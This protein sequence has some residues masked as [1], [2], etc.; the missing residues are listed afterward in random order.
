MEGGGGVFLMKLVSWNV[1]GLGSFEKRREVRQL[2]VEKKPFILCLQETKLAV[3]DDTLCLS[4]WGDPKHAFSYRPSRGASGGLL[5][6]WDTMEVEV[7]STVSQDQVLIIHGKFLRTNE[8]FY[9]FNIYAPCDSSSKQQ[10]WVSLSEKLQL[11]RGEKVCVCGDFNA[12]RSMDERRSSRGVTVSQATPHFNDFIAEN[13]LIDLPLCGRRFT[14]YKGDGTSMS[15]LDRFLLSEDWCLQW[16]NCFQVALLRGLSD[17]CPLQ[18]SVEEED[19]GPRPTRMLKCWQDLPGYKQFV[20]ENWRFYQI[21]GLG[22]FVLREK[23]KMLKTAL[24]EWHSV[25]ARN[26]PG[27]I[28]ALKNRL[29]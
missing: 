20:L 19:W 24:K 15:R 21:T 3:C 4:M 1:R 16:P 9:L 12:I 25:H 13:G 18:L 5:I 29:S 14:W 17:H 7:W 6:I 26:I 28:V 27:K 8:M 22:G 23:F 2:V 10:L 11:L